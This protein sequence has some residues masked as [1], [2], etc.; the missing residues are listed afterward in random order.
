[1]K[2]KIEADI[3]EL[4]QQAREWGASQAAAIRVTDIEVD[5]R[6]S[7]KCLVPLCSHYNRDLLCPPNVIPVAQFREVLSC[8][9]YAILIMLEIPSDDLITP[10]TDYLNVARNSQK[11]LHEVIS[12]VESLCLEKGHYFAAGLIGG[13]CPLCDECVGVKSGLPC[14]H[15]FKARAAMEAMGIDVISTARNAGLDLDF[16]RDGSRSWVGLVLVD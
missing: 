14:R 8:Y 7:L 10:R 11:K 4:C 6:T 16:S 9:H 13:S 3:D 2:S 5:G 1:M 12:R 15:P